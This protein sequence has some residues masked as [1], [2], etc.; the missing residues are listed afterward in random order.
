MVDTRITPTYDYYRDAGSS[1]YDYSKLQEGRN[2]GHNNEEDDD[3]ED[4]AEYLGLVCC[5]VGMIALLVGV[6]VLLSL[7][8]ANS[9]DRRWKTLPMRYTSKAP[10]SA[11][12]VKSLSPGVMEA[13]QNQTELEA[14]VIDFTSIGR[15]SGNRTR[16]LH[17][18]VLVH[19]DPQS[20]A[21]KRN[22]VR[23]SWMRD[24]PPGVKVVFVVPAR[25]MPENTLNM[26]KMESN[27]YKDMVVFLDAPLVPE[28]ELL[29]LEFAWVSRK[30]V[31]FEYLLKTRDSMYVRIQDLMNKLVQ[32]LKRN[33]SN[34][35]LGYFQGNLNARDRK[36]RKH[37]EQG[38][39]LC[40][41]YIRFAHS[42][43]YILSNKLVQRLYSQATYLYPYN[44]E[45]VA[46]GT[47]LSPFKD[48]DWYHDIR[49]DTELGRTRGCRND[50]LVFQSNNLVMQHQKLLNSGKV[51]SME[52]EEAETYMYNFDKYPSKCCTPVSFS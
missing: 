38:W 42:G 2:A 50:W 36:Q 21:H 44:N 37:F 46:M 23:M 15:G 41:K 9:D 51:C 3:E 24:A 8:V 5:I 48:V 19:S 6:G 11:Y 33:K 7:V 43:G 28:S 22:T 10:T 52:W 45:D 34:S 4:N 18:L 29:L 14:R 39:F 31:K 27:N 40:D 35:Y 49:F 32:Q 26:L 1:S 12:P 13:L 25:S 17:L 47:W 20:T 30:N 16:D